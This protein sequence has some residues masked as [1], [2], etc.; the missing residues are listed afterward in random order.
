MKSNKL[1]N[2]LY[3]YFWDTN[4]DEVDLE[5]DKKQ[6]A[7]RVLGL[8]DQRAVNWLMANY[9]ESFLKEVVKS[10]R[11]IAWRSVHFWQNYFN[12]N[13][14]EIRCLKPSYQK[15]RKQVWPY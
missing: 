2:F 9:S 5:R 8:G 15:M 10:T 3:K 12:I 1:P 14:K 11:Q 7:E 4:F 13:K 6:I